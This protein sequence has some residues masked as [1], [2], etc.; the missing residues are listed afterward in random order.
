MRPLLLR[1]LY[2]DIADLAGS[3]RAYL[4]SFF[5]QGLTDVEAAN[6]SHAIRWRTTS[7]TQR[8]FADEFQQAVD[9]AGG[10][11]GHAIGYPPDFNRWGPL[12]KAQYL[13]ITTFLSSYLLS[14]QGDR[15]GMAHAVEGRFPFLDYRLIE[16]CNKL[17]AHLKLRG[18]DEKYLLKQ[19]AHA[20]LPAE[21][22]HRPKRPY[23]APIYRSFFNGDT[24]E[25]ARDLLSPR[26]VAA[27]GLF[28]PG[29]VSQLVRKI[30]DGKRLSETDDMALAGIL[31]SQL[32]YMQFVSDF[33]MPPPLTA[34]DD[35]KVCG[36]PGGLPSRRIIREFQ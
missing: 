31:S 12:Q 15:M 19:V 28:K 1:R 25:Y 21:I 20:W 17:P 8:F 24:P 23:R 11:D 7:R 29:A 9:K 3:G 5:G 34:H 22:W 10:Q 35:V 16:F 6:Y 36:A 26:T 13:E 2:P 30:E 33:K 14:S 32:V 4:I 27:F 18:L